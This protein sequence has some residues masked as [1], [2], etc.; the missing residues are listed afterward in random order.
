MALA[1]VVKLTIT[2]QSRPL[3]RAGFGTLLHL[4]MHRAWSD[5]IKLYTQPGDL[6]TDGFADTDAAYKAA[7]AYF[8]QEPKPEKLAIGRLKT[9]DAV[10]VVV[11]K[12]VNGHVYTVWIDGIGFDYI[13]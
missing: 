7:V 9:A 3:E 10:V 8:A 11:E 6:L 4:S 2:R 5:R 1:D 13:A 12:V